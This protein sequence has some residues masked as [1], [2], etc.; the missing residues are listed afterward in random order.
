MIS[1]SL[2]GYLGMNTSGTWLPWQKH[3]TWMLFASIS[4]PSLQEMTLPQQIYIWH[5]V[6]DGQPYYIAHY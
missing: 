5:R 2:A 3:M 4:L 6:C 1:T